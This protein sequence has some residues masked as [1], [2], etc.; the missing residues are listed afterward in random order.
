M[1]GILRTLE[2]VIGA[3]ILGFV[4]VF[5]FG[6]PIEPVEVPPANYKLYAYS[7]LEILEEVGKLREYALDG[8]TAGIESHLNS[9]IPYFL[10]FNVTIYNETSNITVVPSIDSENV[11]TVSYLLA[12]EAGN[13]SALEV[14]VFIWGYD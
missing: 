2:A 1:K 10:D 12:G 7:G 8:N 6:T 14:R 5:Y 9:Y 4:L 13:Y 11:L 3:T